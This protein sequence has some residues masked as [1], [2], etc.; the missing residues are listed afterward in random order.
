MRFDYFV[1]V[2]KRN[3]NLCTGFGF[4]RGTVFVLI[5]HSL[6]TTAAA[7][8]RRV[9]ATIASADATQSE[10]ATLFWICTVPPNL[11]RTASPPANSIT[12]SYSTGADAGIDPHAGTSLGTCIATSFSIGLYWHFAIQSPRPACA[13]T[14]L[15][16]NNPAAATDT[17]TIAPCRSTTKNHRRR[18]TTSEALHSSHP[19]SRS[20]SPEKLLSFTCTGALIGGPDYSQTKIPQASIFKT[21][22]RSSLLLRSDDLPLSSPTSICSFPPSQV[23]TP[24]EPHSYLRR[25]SILAPHISSAPLSN[26][27][28]ARPTDTSKLGWSG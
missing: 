26:V 10:R 14:S 22:H 7:V 18:G 24:I 4:V 3:L 13:R 1:P 27:S 9:A 23:S 16:T 8:L 2:W 20:A 19:R 6:S 25:T 11:L 28:T 5:S 15:T 21:R 17:D 12:L